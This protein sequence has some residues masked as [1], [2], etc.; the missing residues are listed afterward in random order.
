MNSDL[1]VWLYKQIYCRMIGSVL[2]VTWFGPRPPDVAQ[3]SQP[4]GR[5]RLEIVSHC[6]QYA[7]LSVYQLSSLVNHPPEDIDVD[8]TLY[9][10]KEDSATQKLVDTFDKIDVPNVNWQWHPMTRE[11]LFRRAIGRNQAALSTRADWIWF[12]DCDLIFHRGCLDSV[13]SAL[14]GKATRLAYPQSEE[15]T[16][17]L[18]AEHPM[19]NLSTEQPTV[20]DIDLAL[21]HQSPIEKAKGAFQI[22]HA[23]VARSCGYCKD[24]KHYQQ[25]THRWRKT[26]EDTAFRRL[27]DDE[28]LAVPITGLHRIR[29]QVKGRYA[30][31]SALTQV[32]Q[33]IR[34][35]GDHTPEQ[36]DQQGKK[37]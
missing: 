15:I 32:R 3:L 27:I 7:H 21:F 24:L 18:P 26:F 37:P 2:P 20:V 5:L 8:Y 14:S 13:A 12:A 22:V 28:G 4:K 29:H 31:D 16:E 11:Q 25:P 9:Y 6:W 36:R 23:D 19:V 35:I 30:K 34:Q 10:A 33:S 1:S 17:L